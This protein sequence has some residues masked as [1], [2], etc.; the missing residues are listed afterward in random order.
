M[1]KVISLVTASLR[2]K[3]IEEEFQKLNIEFKFFDAIDKSHTP[4]IC[5]Q[6]GIN[7][8]QGVTDGELGV[9]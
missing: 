6:L 9:L 8:V 1:V 7:N 2:R 3:N 5:H 4:T